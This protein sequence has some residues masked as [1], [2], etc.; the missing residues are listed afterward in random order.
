[1]SVNGRGCFQLSPYHGKCFHS[2]WRSGFCEPNTSVHL[3]MGLLV[4][5]GFSVAP[6]KSTQCHKSQPT[7][8]PQGCALCLTGCILFS[9]ADL[10][11]SPLRKSGPPPRPPSLHTR[12]PSPPH[13]SCES[14]PSSLQLW[15]CRVGPPLPHAPCTLPC[16]CAFL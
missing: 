4:S 1:M 12:L 6:L 5:I 3:P 14:C 8:G 16:S 11:L 7:A 9:W 2:G 10:P 15:F 13:A